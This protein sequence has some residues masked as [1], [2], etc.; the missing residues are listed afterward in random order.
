MATAEELAGNSKGMLWAGRILSGLIVAFMAFGAA[1]GF[2]KPETVQQGFEHMGYPYSLHTVF[3]ILMIGC[4]LIYAIP[5]T[6]VL[7]AILLT[8]YFG[9]ATATHLRIGEPPYFPIVIA[10]LAW[11]GVYLRDKRLRTLVP[12]RK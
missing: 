9:G 6:S 5:Q 3:A 10:V 12:L 8:G 4:T 11:I 2:T 1:I 7:G